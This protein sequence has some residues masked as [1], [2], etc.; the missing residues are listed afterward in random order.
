MLS[1]VSLLEWFLMIMIIFGMTSLFLIGNKN[2]YGFVLAIAIYLAWIAISIITAHY[3]FIIIS[4]AYMMMH[5][6]A[7]HMWNKEEKKK[8]RNNIK[9]R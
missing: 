6:R 5:Y 4:F 8:R 2:K 1:Q 9:L 3:V 7:Y